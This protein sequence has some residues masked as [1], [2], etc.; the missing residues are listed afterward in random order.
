MIKFEND[1]IIVIDNFLSTN[2]FVEMQQEAMQH[3]FELIPHGADIAYKLN[4]GDIYKTTHKYW[5]D[6]PGK[7]HKFFAA[8]K[9]LNIVEAKKYSLMVHAYR[10]GAEIDWHIDYSSVASYS[11]YIH[12]K[13]QPNWGGNL[14]VSDYTTPDINQNNGNVFNTNTSV[15]NPG[16][17]TYY[18]PLPNRLVIIKKVFHKVER[19][20]LAAGSNARISFTGFFK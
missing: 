9:S 12:P 3:D 19:V 16:F 10:A 2:D 11:F 20:D 17:G 6:A 4:T 14:L 8:M 18:A 13:W 15:M 7:F 5:S 1:N